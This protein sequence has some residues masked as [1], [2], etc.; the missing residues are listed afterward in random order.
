MED[1]HT[2]PMGNPNAMSA[3]RTPPHSAASFLSPECSSESELWDREC[4]QKNRP[5]SVGKGETTNMI[6]SATSW[7][8]EKFPTAS[9]VSYK[10][11]KRHN[12]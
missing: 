12:A 5:G 2:G 4:S 11:E 9:L 6:D 1:P 10:N 7:K 3:K 8:Q